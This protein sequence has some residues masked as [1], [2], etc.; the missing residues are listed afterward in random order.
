ML[1]IHP[2]KPEEN[3]NSELKPFAMRRHD[4]RGNGTNLK[5]Y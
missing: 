3:L 5:S 4:V 1:R 2:H